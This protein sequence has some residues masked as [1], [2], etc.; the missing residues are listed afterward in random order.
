[1]NKNFSNVRSI[2]LDVAYDVCGCVNYD[3]PEAVYPL[4]SLGLFNPGKS[5]AVKNNKFAKRHF[6]AE[7]P[8][9]FR[10]CI[11]GECQKKALYYDTMA[12][13]ASDRA[14][15]PHV[16][17]VIAANPD[18]ITR[19]YTIASTLTNLHKSSA[20]CLPDAE[21]VGP[22]RDTIVMDFHSRSGEKKLKEDKKDGD[23]SDTTIYKCEN[24]GRG[25][26]RTRGFINLENLQFI[27][28]D[29]L[30]DRQAVIADGGLD[31][32]IFLSE[33]EKNM[34]DFKPEIKYWYRKNSY[35]GDIAAERG[36]LLNSKSIDMLIKRILRKITTIEITKSYAW[37]RFKR[38]TITVI[39]DENP[40]PFEITADDIDGL[41]FGAHVWYEEA[42]LE[43][44]EE[45]HRLLK[46]WEE[47]ER[48]AKEEKRKGKGK[49][50]GTDTDEAETEE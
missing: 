3:G 28:A 35:L 23:G 9:Q 6:N 19:G 16:I 22:W 29:P 18:M 15:I 14:N 1:M 50:K 26:Y 34:T 36:I 43:Q 40:E 45:N 37:L 5:L 10:Y 32:K 27:S 12:L 31:E 17:P 11:S 48:K 7:N 44:I 13:E 46:E 24:V 30:F 38:L 33:L 2:M 39:C 47:A 4:M 42:T 41:S 20:L 25:E 21:E 49:K 8:K